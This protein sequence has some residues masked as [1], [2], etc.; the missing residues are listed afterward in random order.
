MSTLLLLFA[1]C[2]GSSGSGSGAVADYRLTLIPYTP[3]DVNPFAEADRID[4]LLDNGVGE[5]VRVALDV[6]ASGESALAEDLP[7]LEGTRVEVE[8]YASGELVGW[9]RSEPLTASEGELEATVFVTVPDS[10]ARLGVLPEEWWA[11]QGAALGEGRFVLLGGAGNRS[12]KKADRELE[13]VWTL[14]LGAPNEALAFEEVGTLPEYIDAAG[15][16]KTGRR[17]FTLT[18]LTAGDA[19]QFLLAGGSDNVGYKDGTAIT[20]DCRLFDPESLT[21]S[22]PLPSRDTLHV[23]R[24]NHSAVANQQGG[25][26]VWG[27]YG[28]AP[29]GRFVDQ[30]DGEL[31]DPVSRSFSEVEGPRSGGEFVAGSIGVGLAPIGKDG[32]LVAGG[33]HTDGSGEWGVV[34][35]AFGVGFT[36]EV[37]ML[38]EMEAVA[39]HSMVT[40]ENGDVLAFGGVEDDGGVHD[41]SETLPATRRVQRFD[42]GSGTWDTV[43]QMEFARAGLTA[44]RISE[45]FVLIAGGAAAWGPLELDD[46]ANS[47]VELYD[48]EADTSIVLDDCSEGDAAGG[49]AAP[50][51]SPAALFDPELGVLFAGGVDGAEGAGVATTFYALPRD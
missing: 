50:S 46:S 42:A 7:A 48:V 20:S 13:G 37:T 19:G 44:T 25:V 31:Y 29:E 9:G 36:G 8:V 38:G 27:G 16:T 34:G 41:F 47:C 4:L 6:P 5:P 39:A 28:A 21:F 15:D 33:M 30:Q 1:A 40:L 17:D 12:T 43:G 35:T 14:D 3:P 32:V 49:L 26:L 51:Q 2:T 23:A 18:A 10:L 11:G 45:Q 22:D 24:A